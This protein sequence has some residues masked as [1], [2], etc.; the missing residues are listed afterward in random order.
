MKERQVQESPTVPDV[1]DTHPPGSPGTGG[2]APRTSAHIIWR[3]TLGLILVHLNGVLRGSR[4]ILSHGSDRI[5]GVI[6][7]FLNTLKFVCVSNFREA[8]MGC[9]AEYG[10]WF[11]ILQLNI[12]LN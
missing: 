6:S 1:V 8:F 5:H 9:R 4:F 10:F 2:E 12:N 7:I 3:T 11:N